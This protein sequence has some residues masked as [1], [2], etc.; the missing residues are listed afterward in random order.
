MEQDDHFVLSAAEAR[1]SRNDEGRLLLLMAETRQALGSVMAAFPLTRTGQMISLRD[2]E[3]REIAILDDIRKLD[4]QSRKI[5]RE[6]LE[7]SYFMPRIVDIIDVREELG[8]VT[9]EVETNRG[10]R[11]FQVRHVRQNVRRMG[12]RRF[13]IKDV[14]GNRYEISD[15]S[16]LPAPAVRLIRNYL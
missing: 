10:P 7:R 3:G 2:E 12:R 6:E 13:V 16:E 9:W 15:W 1:F 8:V 5:M 11:T 4:P 14:D